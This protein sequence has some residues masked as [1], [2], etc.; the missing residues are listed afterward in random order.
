MID[1]SLLSDDEFEDFVNRDVRGNL[2]PEFAAKLREPENINRWHDTLLRL[3][4]SVDA[5]FSSARYELSSKQASYLT[6]GD[7]GRQMWLAARA[8]S[9]KW[10][11]GAVRFKNG[12]E[13]RLAEAKRLRHSMA[14]T[15]DFTQYV[16]AERD[17]AI[18]ELERLR[19]AIEDHRKAVLNDEDDDSVDDI[20]WAALNK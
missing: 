13:E 5:Q 17:R 3:K 9:E 15:S 7:K 19:Q 8:A 11:Q 10:R 6:Q 12:V 14:A 18:A 4:R 16:I 20:L 1:L 2:E